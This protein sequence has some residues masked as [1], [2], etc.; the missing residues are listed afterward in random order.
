M[1]CLMELGTWKGD[2]NTYCRLFQ[3]SPLKENYIGFSSLPAIDQEGNYPIIQIFFE[4]FK[5]KLIFSN[6]VQII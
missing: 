3:E 5:V 6:I 4:I 1:I 2:K